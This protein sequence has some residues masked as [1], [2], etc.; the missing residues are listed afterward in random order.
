M[1]IDERIEKRWMRDQGD[2]LEIIVFKY[3]KNSL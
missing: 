3:K 1:M 2:S